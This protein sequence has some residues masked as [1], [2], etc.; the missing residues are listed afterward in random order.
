MFVKN[1]LALVLGLV[2]EKQDARRSLRDN[3]VRLAR[4][5]FGGRLRA[6]WREG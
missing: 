5:R 3:E 6:P 2:V 4:K 1:I